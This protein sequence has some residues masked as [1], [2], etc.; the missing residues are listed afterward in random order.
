MSRRSTLGKVALLG[1]GAAVAAVAVRRAATSGPRVLDTDAD[2]PFLPEVDL[3]H[4]LEGADGTKLH[5]VERGSGPVL[6]LGHGVRLAHRT[7][8]HQLRGLPDDGFRVVAYD[9]RGHGRS[10]VGAHGFGLEQLGDDIRTVLEA[11]DLRDV[12]LVGHSMGGIAAQAFAVHHPAVLRDRVAG[13][14]LMSTVPNALGLWRPFEGLPD[15]IVGSAQGV[16]DRLLTQRSVGGRMVRAGFGR[17]PLPSHLEVTRAMLSECEPETSRL[18]VRPLIGFDFRPELPGI[19][20]P[21][22][23]VVGTADLLTPPRAAR[24]MAGLIPGA[25]LE[26]FPGGGHMLMLERA[27]EINHLLAEFTREVTARRGG[28]G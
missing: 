7:W 14:V 27:E 28:S 5:V 11:L 8:S 23:V 3:E 15:R 25:R 2:N 21:T 16:F 24:V 26:V 19:E 12:V 1:V 10:S 9:Q 4:V 17:A 13:L 22:M 20:V 6:V 18:A